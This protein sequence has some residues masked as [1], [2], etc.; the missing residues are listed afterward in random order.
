[1]CPLGRKSL[2]NKKHNL[3]FT[4]LLKGD[5]ESRSHCRVPNFYSTFVE[6]STL[7][8]ILLEFES[9]KFDRDSTRQL[10]ARGSRP[11][12]KPYSIAFSQLKII[13]LCVSE[14]CNLKVLDGL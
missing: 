8:S 9:G 10:L 2:V 12:P 6:K 14:V 7:R 3:G 4:A 11:Y 1:M 5:F 13:F